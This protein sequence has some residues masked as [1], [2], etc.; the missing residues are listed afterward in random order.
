MKSP[1]Y[2]A[3][4]GSLCAL[5][6]LRTETPSRMVMHTYQSE[7]IIVNISL[8]ELPSGSVC[9][10]DDGRIA[11]AA[12]KV[13]DFQ[14]PKQEFDRIRSFLHTREL[15]P[16]E[17]KKDSSSQI[18]ALNSYVFATAEEPNGE[19]KVFIVPQDHAPKSVAA[20]VREIRAYNRD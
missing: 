20:L 8:I 11:S 10:I 9:H 6:L 3:V 15:T 17:H 19:K 18:E 13:R 1:V 5:V 12:L 14:I 7:G 4:I 16:F 2:L